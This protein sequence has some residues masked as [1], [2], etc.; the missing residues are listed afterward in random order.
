[1]SNEYAALVVSVDAALLVVGAVQFHALAKAAAAKTTSLL[2][3]REASM[4]ALARRLQAGEEPTPEELEAAGQRSGASLFST[5]VLGLLGSTWGVLSVAL[6]FAVVATV[7]WAASEDPDSA[8]W[9]AT[10]TV[11]VTFV[12]AH[13]LV[14]EAL[15]RFVAVVRSIPEADSVRSNIGPE[16]YDQAMHKLNEYRQAQRQP[17]P[18][19]DQEEV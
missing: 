9:L 17:G 11:W 2:E 4:R 19:P 12:S 3:R 14:L 16:L 1:M 8:P 18:A 15:V 6:V 5:A 10:Y 13:F 7:I